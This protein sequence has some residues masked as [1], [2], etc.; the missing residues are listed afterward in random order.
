MRRNYDPQ[1]KYR[2]MRHLMDHGP[3]DCRTIAQRTGIDK[4]RVRNAMFKNRDILFVQA[5]RKLEQGKHLNI[6]SAYEE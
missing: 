4:A 1:L 2:I 6:W 5:G 3:A